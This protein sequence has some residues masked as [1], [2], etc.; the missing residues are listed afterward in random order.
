M[1]V[2][3]HIHKLSADDSQLLY[4]EK[5][6]GHRIEIREHGNLRW[7]CIGGESVQSLV[8]TD[9]PEDPILPNHIAM[10][11][12]LLFYKKPERLL[13]L[14]F[15]GGSFERFFMDR[16]PDCSLTSVD[17]DR[18]II[19]LAKDYFFIPNDYQ[20][21]NQTADK[22][23][24]NTQDLYNIILCDI[25][26]GED[27]PDCLRSDQFF[28]NTFRCLTSDGVFV[29]NLLPA[30]EQALLEILLLVRN[31]FAYVS[32]LE[33][34]NHANVLLFAMNKEPPSTAKL[35]ELAADT[36]SQ[37]RIDLKEIPSRFKYLPIK[38][39]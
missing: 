11:S 10:L 30:S 2:L 18:T 35:E 33:I 1:G 21:I 27:H 22:F 29:L 3:D 14:G 25:F 4:A 8:N 9:S 13:N 37:M 28:A 6:K 23:L 36:Y 31:H 19:Q 34:P 26:N 20:V 16:L 12:A 15:G 39:S 32:L 17:S 7:M 24:K 5:T 38:T